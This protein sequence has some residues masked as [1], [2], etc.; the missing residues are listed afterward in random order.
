M[1]NQ[2]LLLYDPVSSPW[3]PKLRRLC[4]VRGLRLR[5]VE[6]A[7]L[8]RTV[9]ALAQGLRPA[10][11][12]P[13]VQAVPEPVLVLCGLSGPQLDRILRGLRD[14]GVPRTCLKAVLTADNALWTFRAL[15]DE[16]VKERLQLS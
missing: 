1:A 12:A 9:G 13:S 5:L 3:A 14:L 8:G 15:Y 6:E 7:D 11:E 4:A 10:G 2:T 16:L